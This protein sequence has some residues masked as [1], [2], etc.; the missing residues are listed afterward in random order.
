MN[1]YYEPKGLRELHQVIAAGFAEAIRKLVKK[2]EIL[3]ARRLYLTE[4][5]PNLRPLV[6]KHLPEVKNWE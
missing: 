4:M 2:G 1:D 3:Q 5:N 6:V